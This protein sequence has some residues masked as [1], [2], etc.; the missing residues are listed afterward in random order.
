N[1]FFVEGV[2]PMPNDLVSFV[3]TM[4]GKLNQD[5]PE[6]EAQT[7]VDIQSTEQADQEHAADVVT[8]IEAH[9]AP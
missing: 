3:T 9:D 1:A 7:H 2:R 6:M 4:A 8:K 5:I